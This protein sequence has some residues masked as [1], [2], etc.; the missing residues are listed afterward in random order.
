M[1]ANSFTGKKCFVIMP[2]GQ[3]LDLDGKLVD[4]DKIYTAFIKEAITD[5]ELE[6][7]RCDEIE[8]AGSIHSKMFEHI[9]NAEVAIVDTTA[10]NANVFYELGIRHAL[11]KQITILMRQPGTKTPFNIQG[12]QMLDYDPEDIKSVEN[13][14]YKIGEFIKNGFAKQVV[15][16]P[17]YRALDNLRVERKPHNIEKK[18]I[19]LYKIKSVPG[20]EIGVITGDIQNIKEVD[21]WVNSENT[22]M[23][24]ARHYER[25]ISATIRYMGAKK[26]RAG[27]VVEDL[28][29]NDLRDAAGSADV[30]PATV[31]DTTSGEL[32]RTNNV[33][34]IFHAASVYGQVGRGY[35]PIPDISQCIRNAL[36]LADSE[37]LQAEEIRSILLPLMGTGT[38]RLS[39]QEVADQLIDAAVCY[40][41]ENPRSRID[42]IFFLAFTEQ[43]REICRNKFFYDPRIATPDAPESTIA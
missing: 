11:N 23:Q 27:R 30:P 29:A 15:D 20:K 17:V 19:Y 34:K 24:M 42:K 13:A 2:F 37:Q 41:E 4:F 32:K 36:I 10:L 26:D 3:K 25:S 40:V 43:D 12:Y 33:K 28:V 38:T 5:L 35:M 1:T 39:A 18:E 16:S 7:I 8:E 14:K 9:F 6:C 31:I 22:N 21:V